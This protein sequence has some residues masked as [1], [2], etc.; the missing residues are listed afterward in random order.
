M[1]HALKKRIA[2]LERR[3]GRGDW[4]Q[5]GNDPRDMPDWA[6]VA[7]LLWGLGKLPAL[8]SRPL[9]VARRHGQGLSDVEEESS[10][11]L[12]AAGTVLTMQS[13]KGG[14]KP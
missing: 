6:L 7:S 8:R 4:R 11:N 1:N 9:A 3:H 12:K 5:F 14:S 2:R 10:K 13:F